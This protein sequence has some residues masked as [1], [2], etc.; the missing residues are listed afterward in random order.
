MR[1]RCFPAK[2]ELADKYD[3]SDVQVDVGHQAPGFFVR[4]SIRTT[5]MVKGG[6][7]GKKQLH[8]KLLADDPIG[9]ERLEKS[10]KSVGL[11]FWPKSK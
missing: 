1:S 7:S 6:L 10:Y 2:E 11:V 5:D 8:A 9:V 3:G 4:P